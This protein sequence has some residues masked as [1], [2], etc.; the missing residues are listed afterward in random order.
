MRSDRYWQQRF[1]ELEEALEQLTR[2]TASQINA[3]HDSTLAD[4]EKELAAWYQRFADENGVS[5]NE[6]KRLLTS[7]EIKKYRLSL[8]QF[9]DYAQREN[10]SDEWKQ[11][12]QNAYLAREVDR[13]HALETLF[14]GYIERLSHNE[15]TSLSDGLK[16]VYTEGYYHTAFNLQQG[17]GVG[18]SFA[19]VDEHK[20]NAVL[21]KPWAQDG[22]NFSQRIWEH[23]RSLIDTL[24]QEMTQAVT[25][26][27]DY[28]RA[29][30]RVAQRMKV[31]RYNAS[32][33]VMTEAAFASSK[34]HQ[35][36]FKE[37]DVEQYQF[38]ATL[39]SRTS[40]IC[41]D[42]DLRVF[43][44]TEFKPGS[45]APPMHCHCRSCT[46]PYFEDAEDEK[47]I[48][49]GKDGRTYLVPGNMSYRE[50][51]KASGVLQGASTRATSR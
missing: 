17:F 38:I 27:D 1:V 33:L 3:F 51:Q 37:L 21:T 16:K 42:L 47:R 23:K 46:A 50:W 48:A 30:E 26:G 49:R 41:R 10:L 14:R 12:L 25:R 44:L 9:L 39:D 43:P 24:N 35:D 20:L 8:K 2:I 11:R 29:T 4:M 22:K 45:N 32:R 5:Y 28:R 31:S 6:A 36:C 15:E 19:G 34:A 18:H 13:L 7:E 40:E